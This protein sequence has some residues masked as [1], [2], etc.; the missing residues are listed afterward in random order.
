MRAI[1]LA[2]VLAFFAAPAL[3]D[4]TIYD[5]QNGTIGEGVAVTVEG[6]VVTAA[7]GEYSSAFFFAEEP[8]GGQYS[9]VK[10]YFPAGAGVS[11]GDI[12]DITGVTAEYY[13]ETEI[14]A[15]AGTVTVVYPGGAVPAPELVYTNDFTEPWEGVL[16][17]TCCSEVTNPDLGY[18]EWEIDDDTGPAVCDDYGQITYVPTL[19]EEKV[20][21]GIMLYTFGAFKLAPRDDDDIEGCCT[22]AEPTSWGAIKCLF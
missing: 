20:Y 16:V 17:I 19:G 7:D 9:G 14:D 2:V 1:T 4:D 22:A 21:T 13:D 11:R 5:I 10:V 12:V 18:G 15:S 3:A 8:A 6:V